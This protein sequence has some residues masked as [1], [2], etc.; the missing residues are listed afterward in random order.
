MTT[1]DERDEN[2]QDAIIVDRT[3]RS[4]PPATAEV[5]DTHIANALAEFDAVQRR[6]SPRVL[7]LAAAVIAVF[8]IGAVSG[9]VVRNNNT[10]AVAQPSVRTV[11]E[12]EIPCHRLFPSINFIGYA[13]PITGRVAVFLDTSTSPEA[14]VLVAP[15]T[16]AVVSRFDLAAPTTN[17]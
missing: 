11:V 7:G 6:R 9:W 14:L 3:L 8:G 17:N 16:C 10:P 2:E 1:H 4:V 13:T 12:P 5:R 15:D